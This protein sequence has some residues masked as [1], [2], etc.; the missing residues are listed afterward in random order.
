M[1]QRVDCTAERCR[2]RAA[3]VRCQADKLTLP[4]TRQMLFEVAASYEKLANLLDARPLA[5]ER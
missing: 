1:M 4:V 2:M 3:E 5:L